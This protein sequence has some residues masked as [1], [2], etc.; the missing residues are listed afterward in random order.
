M[1]KLICIKQNSGYDEELED[2]L[3]ELDDNF[4]TENISAENEFWEGFGTYSE[5]TE[6]VVTNKIN[7]DNIRE[8]AG[9]VKTADATILDIYSLADLIIKEF[10]DLNG[11]I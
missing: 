8:L 1:A 6:V 7:S 9:K 10:G 4:I 5:N 11:T 2:T 3:I